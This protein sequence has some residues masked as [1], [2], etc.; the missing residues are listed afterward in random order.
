ML[1]LEGRCSS[2]VLGSCK[3][4]EEYLVYSCN[5]CY[6]AINF[7]WNITR[8]CFVLFFLRCGLV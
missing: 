8:V 2:N 3:F 6:F 4:V 1:C 7:L 5:R